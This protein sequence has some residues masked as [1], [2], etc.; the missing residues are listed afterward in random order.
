MPGETVKLPIGICLMAAAVAGA[1]VGG[2]GIPVRHLIEGSFGFF[3]VLLIIL[4]AILFMNVLKAAGVLDS[5]AAALLKTF[6]RRKAL[7]LLT[8]FL[9]V[10]FPGM[11]TGKS[12]A[13]VLTSGPLSLPS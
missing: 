9:L 3:D 13:S 10:M 12:T 1:L 6:Y 2:E 11:I 8:S 5:L 7:L 4:T